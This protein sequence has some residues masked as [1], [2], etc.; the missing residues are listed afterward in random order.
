MR[1]TA[2]V[3]SAT[4]TTTRPILAHK[5]A[6]TLADEQPGADLITAPRTSQLS[7]QQLAR[8][9]TAP[10]EAAQSWLHS[11][12]E[13]SPMPDLLSCLCLLGTFTTDTVTADLRPRQAGWPAV[14]VPPE[15]LTRAARCLETSAQ[16]VRE[17]ATPTMTRNAPAGLARR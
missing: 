5:L 16:N 14:A 17:G 11:T 4:S 15:L 10:A 9:T 3:P 12:A 13:A 8:L 6:F 7:L 1:V 2:A